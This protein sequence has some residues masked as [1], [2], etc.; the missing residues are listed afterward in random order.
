MKSW[1]S[2]WHAKDKKQN[3]DFIIEDIKM[4]ELIDAFYPRAGISKAIIRKT[5]KE[6][7]VI[8]FASKVG[9]IMG[10]DG[11]KIK[12]FEDKLLKKFGKK[13][14]VSIKAVKVPE[15][16]AK[17]MSEFAASQIE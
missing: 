5:A 12:E 3:A 4:R 11:A 1:L 8:L 14:T 10:K 16:S 15:L 13:F 9:L 17:I 6:G 2:E 7:E